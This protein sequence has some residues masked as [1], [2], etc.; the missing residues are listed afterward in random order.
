MSAAQ[1]TTVHD[2][3]LN[4]PQ[5]L[6]F[7]NGSICGAVRRLPSTVRTAT[8]AFNVRSLAFSVA[9][10]MAWN[11]LPDFVSYIQ[12]GPKIV[13]SWCKN[14]QFLFTNCQQHFLKFCKCMN[15]CLR[16]KRTSSTV[17][18]Y[19]IDEDWCDKVNATH[20]TTTRNS[21]YAIMTLGHRHPVP[22]FLCFSFWKAPED[23]C[24]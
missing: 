18:F 2:G 16:F 19:N 12:A 22:Q 13:A 11:C 1:G 8:P 20:K 10:P 14:C 7:G 15:L 21:F 5:T 4:S 17:K 9:D 3:L 6:L 24:Y 23:R